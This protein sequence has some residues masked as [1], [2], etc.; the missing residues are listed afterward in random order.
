MLTD[1]PNGPVR[2]IAQN[3]GA[4]N[5]DTPVKQYSAYFQDDWAFSDRVTLNVGLR[6]D[7]N[8]GVGGLE[9]D[10]SGNRLCQFLSTQ[11]TYNEYYLNDFKGWDCKGEKDD[12]NW[13][14][15]LGFSWDMSGDGHRILRGGIGRFYDFPYTNATVLFPG[16]E[17]QS[18]FGQVYF[19]SNPNGIRNP[20][21]SFFHPGQPLPAAGNLPP[22]A[23]AAVV[24][25]A[26][27]KQA[28]PY[29]DQISLGYSWQVSD[30]LG[31][32]VDA[33]S[34]RYR[35]IP[36][37]FRFNSRLDANGNPTGT[38][39]F[40]SS[41]AAGTARMWMGDGEADYKGVNFSFR[42]R[43][44]KFELQGFYT[45]SEAEGN[46]LAGADEFRLG[47]ASFQSDYQSDR[48]IDSRNPLCGR[49]IGPLYTDAR[50]KLTF[51]GIY[52]APWDI[53]A[54]AFLRYRSAQPYNKLATNPATGGFLDVN[55]DGFTGD[56]DPGA[57]HVN[58]ERGASFSQLDLRV[59]KDFVF[60]GD[61]GIEILAEV[62]NLLDE[63]NPSAFD[64]FGEPHVFAGDPGQGEQRLW[65]FG[66]RV[67]F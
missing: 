9:L 16:I 49:C 12:D 64:R 11:T 7:L 20:D 35:D 50:H 41:V 61:F 40:P 18:N 60:G 22:G 13:A 47:A 15:R 17:V 53:K 34:A 24:N 21:G 59:S 1:D 8:E 32:A 4:S 39:R 65:Q 25:V 66:A 10:Q 45:L 28:T 38:V 55:G 43:E 33:I 51:G 2:D 26:S 36:Y 27:P 67:H 44:A 42:F 62:F 63:D 56:I 48:S 19:L 5:F 29:S 46:V 31:V 3:A 52:N 54:A 14:P 30:R 58:S 57:P 37:R 23:P 6:Y